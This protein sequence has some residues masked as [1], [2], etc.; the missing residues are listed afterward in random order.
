MDPVRG[1][2]QNIY[3]LERQGH[4]SLKRELFQHG[5]L[6]T[7]LMPGFTLL[8]ARLCGGRLG[9]SEFVGLGGYSGYWRS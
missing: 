1:Y 2:I 6:E 8:V 4:R 7:P 3:P 9:G 5:A